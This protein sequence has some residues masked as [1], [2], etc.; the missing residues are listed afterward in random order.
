MEGCIGETEGGGV[1][2]VKEGGVGFEDAGD[3]EGG[4]GVDC[5]TET[6]SRLDPE[7]RK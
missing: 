4:V 6:K 2:V 1:G 5:T 7:G 3:E